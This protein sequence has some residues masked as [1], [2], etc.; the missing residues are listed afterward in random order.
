ME[1]KIHKDIELRSEEVQ[2]V[3]GKIPPWIL[4]QGIT[5]LFIIVMVLLI[6]SFFFKYPDVITAD[7]TLTGRYP[8]AQIVARSSG[9]ISELYVTDGQ[10][11]NI[12]TPLAVIENSASTADVLFL[13][14]LMQQ[15]TKQPDSVLYTVKHKTNKDESNELVLGDIQSVYTSFLTSLHEYENHYSLNYYVKKIAAT[16]EQINKYRTY[17]R[18]QQR[19]QQVVE[20]QF[21]LA[22]QQYNR[23]STLHSR[24]VIS[25]SEHETAKATFLQSRYTLESGYASLENLL[26]QI[27]EMETNLLDME[28]QQAEKENVI[29]QN[30]QTTAEQL[31]NAI[32]SWELNYCLISPIN[33]KITFTKY[34]NEN[35]FIQTGENVFTIVPGENDELIGKALLPIERS[36]KVKTG[37]RVIIRFANF[38]DQEFGTVDGIVSTISLVPMENNYQIEIALPNGLTTNYKKTLPVTHEM[39]ATAEIVTEDISLL[40]RFFMPIRKIFKEG[41]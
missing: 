40:E 13:K 20:E 11:I 38:N 35:Q 5:I 17:Y 23:D 33:G 14:Q 26:I 41:I 32:N 10:E 36:G 25:P 3:M 24:G 1:N 18:N 16:K 37:Q 9:K 4:R 8:V 7:M 12:H 39:K 6:G 19:Q 34:W 27:G 30:Y 15:H 22:I 31:I 2:E 28:L 29:L 21:R